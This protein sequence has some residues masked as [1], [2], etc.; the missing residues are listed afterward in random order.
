[1]VAM[2][3]HFIENATSNFAT[4][5]IVDNATNVKELEEILKMKAPKYVMIEDVFLGSGNGTAHYLH[6]LDKRYRDVKFVVWT[7]RPCTKWDVARFAFFG[8]YGF[9]D[10]REERQEGFS[11]LCNVLKG[12]Q[13]F[14][15]WA[16]EAIAKFS[17]YK[18][19]KQKKELTPRL[20]QIASL[21]LDRKTSQEIADM[22]GIAFRTVE[23][24][25]HTLLEM[26]GGHDE[27]AVAQ[28]MLATRLMPVREFVSDY[29]HLTEGDYVWL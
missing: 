18:P 2:T 10:I 21:I 12:K 20:K 16:E 14:P 9:I 29:E 22:L 28:Y 4:K 15:E 11:A 17:E 24:H 5:V 19:V 1:M 3:T 8:A 25:R 23:N 26:I 6:Q 13:F 7:T 27:M